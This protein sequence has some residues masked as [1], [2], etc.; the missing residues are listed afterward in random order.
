MK[1]TENAKTVDEIIEDFEIK[2]EIVELQKF[3]VNSQLD[4][5]S[6]LVENRKKKLIEDITSYKM[7]HSEEILDKDGFPT[8]KTKFKIAPYTVSHYF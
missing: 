5:L 2:N 8:G 3:Y 4:N 1:K 7:I 6:E